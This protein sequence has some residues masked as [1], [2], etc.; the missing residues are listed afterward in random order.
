M[1]TILRKRKNSNDEKLLLFN[2]EAELLA[3]QNQIN[4]HFL[5]NTL[6]AIR[7]DALKI[8]ATNIADITEAL[9]VYFRYSISGVAS[10]VSILE[11]LDNVRNY[12]KIQQYR[13]GDRIHTQILYSGDDVLSYTCPKLIVQP[14]VENAIFHGLEKQSQAGKIVIEVEELQNKIRIVV[15]DDGIGMT[16]EQLAGVIERMKDETF[17][18]GRQKH[19]FALRNINKRIKLLFGEQYGIW[20]FSVE[21]IGTS[22]NIDLP[23]IRNRDSN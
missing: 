18:S 2:K 16:E 14:V 13:F 8:G 15:S 21:G 4:P 5:Y 9:A 6:E 19:G 3:L 22:V 23:K 7:G 11:E 17:D 1:L 20:I 10:S 12:L